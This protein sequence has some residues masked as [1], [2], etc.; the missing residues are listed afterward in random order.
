MNSNHVQTKGCAED[1]NHV[2]ATFKIE[3]PTKIGKERIGCLASGIQGM[4]MCCR[5]LAPV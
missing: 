1:Q 2:S 3:P 5:Y 4:L